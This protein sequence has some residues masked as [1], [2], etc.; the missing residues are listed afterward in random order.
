MSNVVVQKQGLNI[1]NDK[2]V[3]H[4]V[5]DLKACLR[6]AETLPEWVEED[7]SAISDTVP[8]D[9]YR[10]LS[11]IKVNARRADCLVSAVRELWQI[12]SQLDKLERLDL[13]QA[14]QA[15]VNDCAV[16]DGFEVK[17][18]LDEQF[19]HL[20]FTPFQT[21]LK[22]LLSNAFKH[23]GANSGV[24]SITN[25]DTKGALWVCDNGDGIPEAYQERIFDPF[26]T[27]KSRD[28]VDGSGLG[29]T[30]ARK[31]VEK[32]GGTLK[33][34]PHGPLRGATLQITF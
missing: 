32:W 11:E 25:I 17:I 26:A 10:Y 19:C 34:L 18:Q 14:V 1:S 33:A 24:V 27:L 22:A 7:L 4:F 9:V 28:V 12:D 23:Y 8:A 2:F 29:L 21:V 3:S 5:H 31:H 15:V 20:P 30:I 13:C 6:A 16:P